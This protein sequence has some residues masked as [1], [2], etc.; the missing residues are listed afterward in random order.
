[1]SAISRC[2][3]RRGQFRYQATAGGTFPLI[4]Q[5][6]FRGPRFKEEW[7]LTADP[8]AAFG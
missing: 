5:L 7:L 6:S 2:G 3:K 1:M 4:S 8:K